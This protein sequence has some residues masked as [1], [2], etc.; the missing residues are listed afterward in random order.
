MF[1]GFW[2]TFFSLRYVFSNIF[3]CIRT[4]FSTIVSALFLTVPRFSALYCTCANIP[5]L[6]T[7]S[8][9][10]QD[11]FCALA[12]YFSPPIVILRMLTLL[13][14]LYFFSV[15]FIYSLSLLR[16]FSAYFIV[17]H[18]HVLLLLLVVLHFFCLLLMCTIFCVCAPSYYC[19]WFFPAYSLVKAFTKFSYLLRFF[20]CTFFPFNIFLRF[21]MF[22]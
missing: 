10:A 6:R 14:L 20:F 3:F 21:W 4:F 9:T 2:W 17:G 16:V 19:F 18:A 5:A 1:L 22:L 13:L 7:F 12:G 8:F 11:Y 15:D